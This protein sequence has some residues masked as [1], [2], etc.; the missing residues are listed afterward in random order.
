MKNQQ[1]PRSV[2]IMALLLVIEAFALV[3][4]SFEFHKHIVL[5]G[6]NVSIDFTAPP[7]P[8][9]ILA[10]PLAMLTLITAIGFL[11]LWPGAWLYAMLVQGIVLLFVLSL[12]FTGQIKDNIGYAVM[13]YVIFIVVYLNYNE[14]HSTFFNRVSTVTQIEE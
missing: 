12:H 3:G 8:L 9:G 4:D 6:R 2:T 11:R 1:R 13:A 14:I 10:I 5:I 7:S